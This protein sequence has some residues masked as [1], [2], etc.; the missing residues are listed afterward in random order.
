M[1]TATLSHATMT[2]MLPFDFD[3]AAATKAASDARMAD[4]EL[5]GRY[6]STW[7]DNFGKKTGRD[8]SISFA[9]FCAAAARLAV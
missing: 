5:C 6:L 3:A 1:T 7:A 9:A 4:R 8:K 2:P